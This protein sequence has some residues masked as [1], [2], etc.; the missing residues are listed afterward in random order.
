[1]RIES[2]HA[3]QRALNRATTA[4][5]RILAQT[6]SLPRVSRAHSPT[7]TATSYA[8]PHHP[9]A[10]SPFAVLH[11]VPEIEPRRLG[12]SLLAQTPSPASCLRMQR[13]TTTTPS[14]SPLHHLPSPLSTP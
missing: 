12:F 11:G 7:T 14:S 8:P 2:E 13:P 4:R 6:P 10:P 9:S 3:Y 1:M 5:F